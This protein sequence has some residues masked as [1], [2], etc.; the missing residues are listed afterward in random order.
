MLNITGSYFST[1]TGVNIPSLYKTSSSFSNGIVY[2]TSTNI[3]QIGNNNIITEDLEKSLKNCSFTIPNQPQSQSR[4]ILSSSLQNIFAI[5]SNIDGSIQVACQGSIIYLYNNNT[6]TPIYQDSSCAFTSICISDDG[7]YI[8]ACDIIK[9]IYSSSD[10]GQTFTQHLYN[11]II[12]VS[13]SSN[14][15]YQNAISSSIIYISSNYGNTWTVSLPLRGNS[16]FNTICMTSDGMKQYAFVNSGGDINIFYSVNYG[17]LFTNISFIRSKIGFASAINRDG[18]LIILVSSDY[19]INRNG[20]LNISSD[21]IIYTTTNNWS[22]FFTSNTFPI[23]PGI[24]PAISINYFVSGGLVY[25]SSDSIIW[26]QI[27]DLPLLDNWITVA[28]SKNE[29]NVSL[30]N[31]Q[32]IYTLS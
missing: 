1:Y 31:L 14:G 7:M 27:T 23:S 26:S 16:V 12:S 30:V 17:V 5:A 3:V 15:L 29:Q 4:W 13:M 28:Q 25:Y 19:I 20:S 8:T 11:G 6:W 10:N 9:G 21:S 22:T 2:S 18:S 24:T 32:G